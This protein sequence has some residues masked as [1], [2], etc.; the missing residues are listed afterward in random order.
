MR[1][2]AAILLDASRSSWPDF[3]DWLFEFRMATDERGLLAYLR[4]PRDHESEA[5]TMVRDLAMCDFIRVIASDAPVPKDCVGWAV[6]DCT[7]AS[8]SRN[9]AAEPLALAG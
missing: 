5:Q 6:I 8:A 1:R 2:P 3:V 9:T 7:A 4:P